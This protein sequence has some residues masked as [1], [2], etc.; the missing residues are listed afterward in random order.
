MSTEAVT[1]APETAEENAQEHDPRDEIKAKA[2]A[3]LGLTQS[4]IDDLKRNFG[5]AELS[6]IGGKPYVYRPIRRRELR[7]LTEENKSLGGA[8]ASLEEKVA[9]AC[10][11]R[12][13]LSEIIEST[14]AGLA[15][16]LCAM[17]YNLSDFD[18]DSDPIEL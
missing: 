18:V 15:S 6:F 16:V 7:Q 13:Q 1:Q 3:E 12:P 17:I 9:V 11:V 5:R 4:N 2:Y 14:N 10:T 8:D